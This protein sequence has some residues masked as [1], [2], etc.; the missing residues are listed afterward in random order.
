MQ[1]TSNEKT[2]SYI[3]LICKYFAYASAYAVTILCFGRMS[4]GIISEQWMQILVARYLDTDIVILY[5]KSWIIHCNA[6]AM[7]FPDTLTNYFGFSIL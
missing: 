2:H 4:Y 7:H 5:C 3:Q 6:I 1:P